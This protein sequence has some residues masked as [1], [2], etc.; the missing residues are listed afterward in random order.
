MLK[1]L[2]ELFAREADEA[3]ESDAADAE[4]VQVATCVVLMETAQADEQFSAVE[5][6][7]IVAALRERFA[8]SEEKAEEL[9]A[10]ARVRRG[11]H[12]DLW[13]FTHAINDGCTI[14]EKKRILEEVWRVIYADGT[15]DAHED[16]LVHKLAKLLNLTHPQLIEAKLK[17]KEA[18]V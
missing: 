14:A 18:A 3:V 13:H 15:L 6:D 1:Q 17:A 12:Y 7:R 4:R 9:I 10:E 8:L 16:Y 5:R 2:K 11:D